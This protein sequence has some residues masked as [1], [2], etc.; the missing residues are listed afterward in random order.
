MV[1]VLIV[2]GKVSKTQLLTQCIFNYGCKRVRTGQKWQMSIK[3]PNNQLQQL[4]AA[5]AILALLLSMRERSE[6]SKIN[7]NKIQGR[8]YNVQ[9]QSSVDFDSKNERTNQ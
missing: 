1:I 7:H 5:K 9:L 2:I 8:A 3:R 6:T 4:H